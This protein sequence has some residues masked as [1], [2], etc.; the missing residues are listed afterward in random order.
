MKNFYLILKGMGMGIAEVIPG[1]SGGTIA[2]ITGIYNELL[3]SIKSIDGKFIRLLFS[4][5]FKKALEKLN[6]SFLLY[7]FLG[8]LIGLLSGIF[9]ITHLLE[10]HPEY[11]W[12]TFFALIL[13][14]V[15]LLLRSVQLKAIYFLYMILAAVLAFYITGL[16]PI[17][18][19]PNLLYIF[20]GGTLA[21][22]ALVLP[23][24][25]GSFILLLLG[26]YT[27]IVP[28]L[29]ELI[30]EPDFAKFKILAIFGLG[31]LV[32]LATFARLISAAFQKH[33][34]VTIMIMSGFMLGSLNKIWPW[35]NPEVLL[36]KDTG[37]T[38]A[39]TADT[40]WPSELFKVIQEKNVW[41][42]EYFDNPHTTAVVICM[43]VTAVLVG[44]YA[45]K[46]PKI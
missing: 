1:V 8:M 29:K 28:T 2:F 12:G 43:V 23:G 41:P 4:G 17:S 5:Q 3:H 34:D 25:S 14:S 38:E 39:F 18:A 30:S 27:L 15:P 46:A 33:K 31:C 26:L 22:V 32:G 40:P 11:L 10:T 13:A 35:R 19:S 24:I 20:F 36:N 42:G 9:F 6:L 45:S 7:V 21:I 16:T 37:Q 44:I